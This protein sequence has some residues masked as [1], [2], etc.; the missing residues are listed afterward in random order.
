MGKGT[1]GFECFTE[2]SR[3]LD[4]LCKTKKDLMSPYLLQ[5]ISRAFGYE[6]ITLTHYQMEQFCGLDSVGLLA[7]P[8]VFCEYESFQKRDPFAAYITRV[9]E[10]EPE[11]P[12]LQSSFVFQDSYF[13]NE[14][15]QFLQR[16]GVSWALS[17]PIGEYRLTVYK[18][19]GEDDFTSV[20]RDMLQ[21]LGTLLRDRYRMQRR[22]ESQKSIQRLQTKVLDAVDVGMVCYSSSRQVSFYNQTAMEFL[23]QVFPESDIQQ[24]FPRIFDRMIRTGLRL[25]GLA[26]GYRMELYGHTLVLE[27]TAEQDSAEQSFLLTIMPTRLDIKNDEITQIHLSE[28]EIQICKL[29]L[30]GLSYQQVANTL[31]ISL[32]TVRSHVKNI[33][34]KTGV[35]NL[36]ALCRF[37][38]AKLPLLEKY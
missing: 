33:Y 21:L 20:E 17:M 36:R 3:D 14:Y 34:E 29:F 22:L 9:C 37:L 6:T 28:R 38:N 4:R 32:N 18:P 31:F 8:A 13:Q 35:N 2:F 7:T 1:V 27:Q 11:T 16:H 15:Y 19:A 26:T 25:Q 10:Q 5:L 30:Q 24:V 23:M 12:S